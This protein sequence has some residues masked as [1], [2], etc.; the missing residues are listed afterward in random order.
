MCKEIECV[1]DDNCLSKKCIKNQCHLNQN[2]TIYQCGNRIIEGLSS[3][4]HVK[5]CGKLNNTFC[6][7]DEE[8]F[9]KNYKDNKCQHE[10]SNFLGIDRIFIVPFCLL[11]SFFVIIILILM[12]D[13]FNKHRKNL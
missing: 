8:C 10:E 1:T 13:K 4:R 6:K 11:I 7:T 3:R 2:K 5:R 9:E 12:I